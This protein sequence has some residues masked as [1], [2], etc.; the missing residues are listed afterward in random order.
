VADKASTIALR[1]SV[2]GDPFQRIN[3]TSATPIAIATAMATRRVVL[4]T[5]PTGFAVVAGSAMTSS[6]LRAII[7]GHFSA[8]HRNAAKDGF[9]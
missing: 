3:N 2:D 9:G 5:M 4:T 1:K 7:A 6:I 8:D